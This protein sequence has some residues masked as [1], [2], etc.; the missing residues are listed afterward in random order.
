MHLE[1]SSK[2]TENKVPLNSPLC[3]APAGCWPQSPQKP[4]W[5]G[6]E[7]VWAWRCPGRGSATWG[8]VATWWAEGCRPTAAAADDFTLT[9]VGNGAGH[10]PVLH[11]FAFWYFFPELRKFL[12]CDTLHLGG[13]EQEAVLWRRLRSCTGTSDPKHLKEFSWLCDKSAADRGD[14]LHV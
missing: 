11:D 4:P 3:S 8:G 7:Q 12:R 1:I 9:H 5:E 13:H 2:N 14:V 6:S 10:T